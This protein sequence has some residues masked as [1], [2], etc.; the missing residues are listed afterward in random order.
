MPIG[1]L[2][3]KTMAALRIGIHDVIIPSENEKD[4][5]EIDPLVRRALNF[6]ATDH[7]DQIL[8]VALTRRPEPLTEKGTEA[9]EAQPLVLPELEEHGRP[10]L[11]Q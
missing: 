11:R 5:E 6:I 2:R 8:D 4:L 9:T 3:E 1:G 10:G 7:V